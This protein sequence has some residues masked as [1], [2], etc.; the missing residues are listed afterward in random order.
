MSIYS[1]MYTFMD[2]GLCSGLVCDAD[3]LQSW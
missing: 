3:S 1:G 2:S